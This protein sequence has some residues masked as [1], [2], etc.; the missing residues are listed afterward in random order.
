MI[1]WGGYVPGGPIFNTGGRYNLVTDTWT[2]TSTNNAPEARS[3]STGVWTGNEMII[4]GGQANGGG[5]LNTGGRYNPI[6]DSWTST[7]TVNAP[8][9]RYNHTAV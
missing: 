4:W 9:A 6:T 2:L 7:S 5:A 1:I 8:D 3:N